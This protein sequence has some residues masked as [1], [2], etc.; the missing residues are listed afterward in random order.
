MEQGRR[1]QSWEPCPKEELKL[2]TP[3]LQQP[4][5]KQNQSIIIISWFK[6]RTKTLYIHVFIYIFL[7]TQIQIFEEKR[8]LEFHLDPILNTTEGK[9]GNVRAKNLLPDQMLKDRLCERTSSFRLT[10]LKEHCWVPAEGQKLFFLVKNS[11]IY[12]A[13]LPRVL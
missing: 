11:H 3:E 6:K 1:S 5:V 2:E 13:Y 7:Y 10:A 4:A 8:N 9:T 12:P